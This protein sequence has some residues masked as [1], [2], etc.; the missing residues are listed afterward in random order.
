MRR[1]ILSALAMFLLQPGFSQYVVS[2]SEQNV[3]DDDLHGRLTSTYREF[4]KQLDYDLALDSW[5]TLFNEHPEVGE[6]LYVDGVTMYQQFIEDAPEGPARNGLIDTLMLIYDQRMALFDGEGNILGRKGSD[7]LR[8]KSDDMEQVQAAYGMLKESLDIDGASSREAVLLNF[9]AAGLILYQNDVLD[10]NQVMADYFMVMGLLDQQQGSS[11]RRE[12]TR[13]SIEGMIQKE[14]ILTCEGLDLYYGPQFENSPENA[15]LLKKIIQTYASAGCKDA[16][17]YTAASE[18]LYELDPGSES[19]H[20]LAMLFIGK[21]DLEKSTFYLQMALV[22][23]QLPNETRAEWLYELSIV[24]LAKGEH[25]EAI[26]FAR[27]AIAN[28]KDYGEAYLV[29]GDAFVASRKELG[30]DFQQRSAYWA[31][32]DMYRTAA[33]LNPALTDETSQKLAMC[34]AQFPHKEDIFFHDLRE[35]ESFHVGGCIMEH[36]T[37]RSRVEN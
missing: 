10:N 23:D 18:Q 31:A 33:R 24:C 2:T 8:Y 37:V 25:C 20:Q 7:L 12:R 30:D 26:S 36:T 3:S 19:A 29:A 11:S 21:E 17:L 9:M 4:F 28:K 32:A 15:V 27:E 1:L 5:W 14:N 16:S 6:R 35:G 13:A 34:A 22:D